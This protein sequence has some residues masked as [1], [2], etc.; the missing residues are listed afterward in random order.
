[1]YYINTF[2]LLEGADVR[3][4]TI[5]HEQYSA[6]VHLFIGKGHS[7]GKS[8]FMSLTFTYDHNTNH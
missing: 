1:M 3:V 7:P 8:T 6:I 5:Q 4:N 2:G